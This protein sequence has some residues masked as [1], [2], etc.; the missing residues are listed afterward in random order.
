MQRAKN[1]LQSKLKQSSEFST[2]TRHGHQ[3]PKELSP[4]CYS[5]FGKELQH[6]FL[7]PLPKFHT[8]ESKGGETKGVIAQIATGARIRQ[9]ENQ[10]HFQQEEQRFYCKPCSSLLLIRQTTEIGCKVSKEEIIKL[11]LYAAPFMTQLS[12]SPNYQNSEVLA[13]WQIESGNQRELRT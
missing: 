6:S 2:V 5:K 4:I 1:I 11:K 7:N 3:K 8:L 10:W 12:I 9:L 13:K